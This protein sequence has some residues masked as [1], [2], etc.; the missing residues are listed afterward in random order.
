MADKKLRYEIEVDA[1][2]GIK[3]LKQVAD[4]TE[5]VG[6]AAKESDK[7]L[8]G[9]GEKL[10]K[11][12][13]G[14]L[15]A[16][17]AFKGLTATFEKIERSAGILNRFSGDISEASK[18]VNGLVSDLE[19]MAAQQKVTEAGLKLSAHE[20]ANLTV[21]AQE[22]AAA[23]GGDAVSATEQ[24]VEA[25]AQGEQGGLKRFGLATEG[26]TGVVNIQKDALK[27]L[28]GKYGEVEASADTLAGSILTLGNRL[29]NL[30]TAFVDGATEGAKFKAEM[31]GF[32]TLGDDTANVWTSIT[33]TVRELG[34]VSSF[35]AEGFGGMVQAALQAG[36]GN[37]TGLKNTIKELGNIRDQLAVA[38]TRGTGDGKLVQ[39]GKTEFNTTTK[40]GPGGKYDFSTQE[41]EDSA[42]GGG[43]GPALS[44]ADDRAAQI[45][46]E[47]ARTASGRDLGFAIQGNSASEAGGML[48]TM[49]DITDTNVVEEY[50][51]QIGEL[52]TAFDDIFK[53]TPTAAQAFAS[54]VD[55]AFSLVSSSIAQTINQVVAGEKSM[56]EAMEALAA[57]LLAS[58][59]E[60]LVGDGMKNIFAGLGRVLT[61]YGADATG[62]GLIALGG[63][64]IAG[65]VALGAAGAAI[66]PPSAGGASTQP[67]SPQAPPSNSSAQREPSTT[68]VQYNA[69]VPK[70]LVGQMTDGT[71]R[72]AKRRQGAS[73][74]GG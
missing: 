6:D 62:A 35:A 45:A 48:S 27:N 66:A 38:L 2:G 17:A 8:S 55:G 68:I 4:E 19:L 65:G 69:P 33:E 31:Q 51:Q 61:S 10:E 30:T 67:T 41:F 42:P 14:A 29:E 28:E 25:M 26:V 13:V 49:A 44:F 56:S 53:N 71:L 1:D 50:T 59:G 23:T 15:A 60:Y 73:R 5:N 34:I 64:E 18:R 63:A 70:E 36:S 57:N 7:K 11:V 46:K 47:R 22:Y 54:S 16:V 12:A 9:I 20:F 58:L 32:K 3:A 24:L 40:R 52:Q 39:P 37:F 21:A 74:I 72:A 43:D